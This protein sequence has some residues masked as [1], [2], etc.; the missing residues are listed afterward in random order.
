MGIN[1]PNHLVIIYSIA[2]TCIP[3]A[4]RLLWVGLDQNV[5]LYINFV[6]IFSSISHCCRYTVLEYLIRIGYEHSLV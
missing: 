2:L 1:L 5:W 4:L 3:V 6:I